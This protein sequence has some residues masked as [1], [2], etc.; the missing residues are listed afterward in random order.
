[1]E[2][3]KKIVELRGITGFDDPMMQYLWDQASQNNWEIDRF[4]PYG[5][6]LSRGA[7]PRISLTAHIDKIGLLVRYIDDAGFIYVDEAGGWDPYVLLGQHVWAGKVP[8]PG[9]ISRRATHLQVKDEQDE[10][11]EMTDI[12]VDIGAKNKEDA[13]QVVA[14][15]DPIE[16][17]SKVT[18]IADDRIAGPGLDDR[19]GCYVLSEVLKQVKSVRCYFT[20][21]EETAYSLGLVRLISEPCYKQESSAVLIGVDAT[22]ATDSPQH[23]K[24]KHGDITIEGGPVIARGSFISEEVVDILRESKIP[25]QLEACGSY[26]GADIDFAPFVRSDFKYAQVSIPVR[27]MHTPV[28][29]ASLKTIEATIQL[30]SEF[31]KKCQ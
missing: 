2:D 28:E 6:A 17:A 29:M 11:V 26:P 4:R 21:L 7:A 27:Y 3:L 8:V 13:Q 1:L 24:E 25:Y 16:I 5:I 10:D 18:R 30:L 20:T 15:G 31:I 22:H 14:V 12:V 19:V 23:S 9:V